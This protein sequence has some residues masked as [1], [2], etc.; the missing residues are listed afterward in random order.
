MTMKQGLTMK[1]KRLA[2]KGTQLA[3]RRVKK[4]KRDSESNSGSD[5]DSHDNNIP[6]A[7]TPPLPHPPPLPAPLPP[8]HLTSDAENSMNAMQKTLRELQNAVGDLRVQLA[9][10]KQQHSQELRTLEARL[11]TGGP[12][13]VG[14]NKPVPVGLIRRPHETS[15]STLASDGRIEQTKQ[16]ILMS[17][18]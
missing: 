6:G 9:A 15:Q 4:V 5:E 7:G 3:S 13:A 2:G 14:L 16:V 8:P 17:A 1:Q 12:A 18:Q 10:T 11:P